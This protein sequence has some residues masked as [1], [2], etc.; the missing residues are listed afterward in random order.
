MTAVKEREVTYVEKDA[1]PP[2]VLSND[3]ADHTPF[4]KKDEYW[5]YLPARQFDGFASTAPAAG[6][7]SFQVNNASVSHSVTTGGING[8]R[9]RDVIT[10]TALDSEH[11]QFIVTVDKAA[12][13][14][15]VE[16]D[17]SATGE[18]NS[19]IEINVNGQVETQIVLRDK[20]KGNTALSL[21]INIDKGAIV[22]FVVLTE[23]SATGIHYGHISANVGRDASLTFGVISLGGKLVR[24][25]I[26]SLFSD[27]SGEIVLLGATHSANGQYCEHR[28]VVDHNMVNCR[29]YV[30][31]RSAVDGEGTHSVWVGDTIIRYNATGSDTYETN[32]NL[33]L[34]RGARADSVP[35]L[36][37]ETGEVV[38]AGHSSA[39]GRL[40]DEH[41]FYLTSR[42]MT[43]H[44]ALKLIV[45]GFFANIV[46]RMG[47]PSLVEDVVATIEAK[48]VNQD[49]K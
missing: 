27:S 42:G 15:L 30:D 21:A 49:N 18:S 37:I 46:E 20:C 14:K 47:I 26:D 38:G 31:F 9:V 10:A 12:S 13:G 8:L 22:K 43:S 1:K 33:V 2:L 36:E 40:D 35:N 23:E 44:E 19:A 6:G 5:R 29:S 16:L 39:T 3:P 11:N 34:S 48:L 17:L 28:T 4:D 45:V 7:P 32:R 25:S 24:R 41:I